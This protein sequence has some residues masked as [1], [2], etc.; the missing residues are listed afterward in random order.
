[1]DLG[2]SHAREPVGD[3]GVGHGHVHGI[4]YG[5]V[6]PAGLGGKFLPVAALEPGAVF[7][8]LVVVDLYPTLGAQLLVGLGCVFCHACDSMFAVVTAKL[9]IGV[10]DACGEHIVHPVGRNR[11]GKR[12]QLID[13][14]LF[15]HVQNGDS[16]VEI[17]HCIGTDGRIIV[18]GGLAKTGHGVVQGLFDNRVPVLA[19]QENGLVLSQGGA[20]HGEDK[21]KNQSGKFAYH[22][23]GLPPWAVSLVCM[24]ASS[25]GQKGYRRVKR[26]R[27][28]WRKS[29]SPRAV[30]GV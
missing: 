20:C 17:E 29:V 24:F 6:E 19:L 25:I 23:H 16:V 15:F 22:A 1:M 14:E 18:A 10:G 12:F 4:A 9:G 3:P 27:R 28:L 13:G 8:V 5:A 7:L 30:Q 11:E 26:A 21:E 2:R